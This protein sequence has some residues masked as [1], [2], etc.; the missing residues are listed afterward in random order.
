MLTQ[1]MEMNEA[2][3]IDRQVQSLRWSSAADFP[4]IR[5]LIFWDHL[6]ITHI[7]P[8]PMMDARGTH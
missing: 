4:Y 6:Y 1:E 7:R 5:V 2:A 3:K 8:K